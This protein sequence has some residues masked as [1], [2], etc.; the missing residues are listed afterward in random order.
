MYPARR[1][2]KLLPRTRETRFPYGSQLLP[3]NVIP[4]DNFSENLAL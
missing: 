4:M 1:S 2:K 3:S